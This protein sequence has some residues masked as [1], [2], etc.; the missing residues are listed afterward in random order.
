MS[1]PSSTTPPTYDCWVDFNDI[2]DGKTTV[3]PKH[4]AEH[5]PTVTVG[6]V[7]LAGDD[8]GCRCRAKVASLSEDEPHPITLELDMSTF[9]DASDVIPPLPLDGTITI[10]R[11]GRYEIRKLL[12]E[13]SGALDAHRDGS[14]RREGRAEGAREPGAAR[15]RTCPARSP[16]TDSRCALPDTWRAHEAAQGCHESTIVGSVRAVWPRTLQ[17]VKRW[18]DDPEARMQYMSALD[19]EHGK[20]KRKNPS[21]GCPS[22]ITPGRVERAGEVLSAIGQNALADYTTRLVLAGD[23]LT[24]P[25]IFATGGAPDRASHW[26]PGHL[27]RLP[28]SGAARVGGRGPADR[29]APEGAWPVK[30]AAAVLTDRGHGPGRE[31]TAR[32]GWRAR[33]GWRLRCW[34]DVLDREHAPKLMSSY[35]FT[36]EDYEGIRFRD[37]GWGCALAY[38]GDADYERAH[39]ESDTVEQARRDEVQTRATLADQGIDYDEFMARA[40]RT[41]NPHSDTIQQVRQMRVRLRARL[42]WRQR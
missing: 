7:V 12:T 19:A 31:W 6:D 27:Q 4:F 29:T 21:T 36:F 42:P 13:G 9:T 28:P 11:A 3:L 20:H 8:E 23:D 1:D 10:K 15:A 39:T 22:C 25:S 38:I 16:E 18:V 5:V 34:A 41:T 37:D 14:A 2:Q 32:R 17:D 30:R 26:R 33:I 35:S 40:M 24:R